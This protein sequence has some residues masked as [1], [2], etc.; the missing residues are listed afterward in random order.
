M[1]ETTGIGNQW[2]PRSPEGHLEIEIN[3][4][5]KP[6]A[7][8]APSQPLNNKPT[9]EADTYRNKRLRDE[10]KDNV[11][12]LLDPQE[13]TEEMQ[14]WI[15]AHPN[16]PGMKK[17]DL[18][19]AM[20][21]GAVTL[22]VKT[23]PT[24]MSDMVVGKEA[25]PAGGMNF[26]PEEY[27]RSSRTFSYFNYDADSD[28][29]Q[30]TNAPGRVAAYAVK[31]F[32]Q[33]LAESLYVDPLA[34]PMTQIEQQALQG[35]GETI[36]EIV[37]YDKFGAEIWMDVPVNPVQVTPE[38]IE[39]TSQ[40]LRQYTMPE[41]IANLDL[42]DSDDIWG[43]AEGAA[44]VLAEMVLDI[45]GTGKLTGGN[46]FKREK[47][48]R[49]YRKAINRFK[50]VSDPRVIA[51]EFMFAKSPNPANKGT[52]LSMLA[53]M[54]E[55]EF[56]MEGEVI[57]LMKSLDDNAMSQALAITLE[58]YLMLEVGRGLAL[59]GYKVTGMKWLV[60]HAKDEMA[61]AEKILDA[62][63]VSLGG[64]PAKVSARAESRI[65]RYATAEEQELIKTPA[66]R[67]QV[68]GL[69]ESAA[70]LEE[71]VAM[72]SAGAAKKGWY[73]ESVKALRH[74]FGEDAER[75]ATLLSA[76]SPQTSVES[77]LRNAL[78]VWKNWIK[79][80][81]PT[82]EKTI[83]KIMGESVEGNKGADSI[84][85]AWKNNTLRALQGDGTLKALSGPKVD[86][87]MRNL[88]GYFNE[89]TN[90]TWMARALEMD[91]AKDFAGRNIKESVDEVGKVSIKKPG[92]IAA[93]ILA[94]Q[95]AEVMTEQ[96]GEVWT[97]AEI[98]E[99]I[100]S[101]TKTIYEARK[102]KGEIRS[103]PEILRSGEITD[104]MIQDTPDFATMFSGQNE[105]RNILEEA[106]YAERIKSL[107]ESKFGSGKAVSGNA[108]QRRA[109]GSSAER[110]EQT[111]RRA[112]AV[113]A[114]KAAKA[115]RRKD[116]TNL[117][118][119]TIVR[120]GDTG[121]GKP[122]SFTR[123][124][125][126]SSGALLKG[127]EHTTYTLD[128]ATRVKFNNLGISTP[129]LHEFK[130]PDTFVKAI[131]AAKQSH[132]PIGEMVHIYPTKEYANMR[133]FITADGKAGFA[134]K[135]DGDI[136]SVFN[137]KGSHPSVGTHLVALAIEQGGTKLDAFSHK[138]F[139][140]RM[141]SK[142]GMKEVD[143][144]KWDAEIAKTDLP[145]W[146]YKKLKTPDV[147]FMELQ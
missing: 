85:D 10:G 9:S 1:E 146:D 40:A 46:V 131:T 82:D 93:N 114:A 118:K 74:V 48:V 63:N 97:A 94:R 24:T 124:I 127:I 102:A 142:V 107:P 19:K 54:L 116:I 95:A 99:T 60:N 88:S 49:W 115:K 98:Q 59:G 134:I 133:T 92:Y 96:T 32:G 110:L 73:R 101:W 139:L 14:E 111:A 69:L 55:T 5:R 72:A 145:N 33:S 31:G 147:V 135:P 45:W 44:G 119:E 90:D 62:M 89:V 87:F 42:D 27:Y 67:A 121:R 91:Q 2:G 47:A 12:D 29:Y 28:T 113:A 123:R 126:R 39:S 8:H 53:D 136:V 140:P 129:T 37:G 141:Y 18:R 76:T 128:K 57:E 109:L 20:D 4:E 122:G 81:R 56:G 77:N 144:F 78:N 130:S 17:Y 30:Y 22:G 66:Q 15:D 68:E 75:F 83:L 104:E 65:K 52:A 106:G 79:A 132:G 58:V 41:S 105:F 35:D 120:P 125:G 3:K 100:W 21:E 34:E 86:S 138:N 84:L 50:D 7:I 11:A 143:R 108:E 117:Y 43:M 16:W 112:D 103:I 38:Q 70:T 26:L 6:V 61:K 80:G 137:T 13:I 36:P 25:E 71:V 51:G 64:V 23:K